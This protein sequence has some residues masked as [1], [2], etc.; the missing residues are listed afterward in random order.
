MILLIAGVLACPCLGVVAMGLLQQAGV[1][2]FKTP[3]SFANVL[4]GTLSFQGAAWVLIYLFLRYHEVDWRDAFGLRNPRLKPSLVLALGVLAVALPVVLGL[5]QVSALVMEKLGW[6]PEGQEAVDLFIK[7]KSWWLRG[8]L[9]VFAMVLAPVAEEFVFR[10]LLYP[11][12]KQLGRPRLAWLGVS[13]LFAV[14]HANLPTLLPLF[15]FA[16]LLTWLYEKTDC[17]LAPILAHSLF[18]TVNLVI[19]LLQY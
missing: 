2:V 17:L 19:L 3:D 13:F 10:G 12:L 9:A 16:L 14:I 18:N 11:F 4:L 8:Y 15:I 7:N 5:Q 6:L 1:G